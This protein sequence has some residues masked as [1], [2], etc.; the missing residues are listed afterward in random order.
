LFKGGRKPSPSIEFVA[1]PKAKIEDSFEAAVSE[2]LGRRH[3][4]LPSRFL[5]DARGSE[6]FE[7]IT[8]LPEYYLTRSE[9]QILESNA[10]GIVTSV[11]PPVSIVELGSGSSKKTTLLIESALRFQPALDYTTIDISAEFLYEAAQ[12]LSK[13]YPQVSITAVA[14]EYFA[15]LK[16]LRAP[17]APRLFIFLGSNIGNFQDSEAIVFLT[18]I[19]TAMQPND[20]LL[21]GIDLAKSPETVFAAYN[22]ASGVTAEFNKNILARINR[23]LGG[24]FDLECFRHD[25]PYLEDLGRVE[26]HL[27][28]E[29]DQLVRID[30]LDQTFA[31]RKGEY[32]HTEN[33][34]KYSEGDFRDI[35]DEAGLAIANQ[36]FDAKEWFGLFTLKPKLT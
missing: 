11:G 35:V 15:G 22:D 29:A 9:Q 28:S 18:A 27:V 17:R 7:A 21:I 10:D 26:M 8:T 20:Q 19:R 1:L 24:N 16:L 6:L 25:A 32:I 23:E 30:A 33:S 31:F 5:Y 2:G 3:K 4:F 14:A 36:W 13:R 34:R 12:S